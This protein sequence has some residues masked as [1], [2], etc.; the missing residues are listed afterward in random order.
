[1][2]KLDLVHILRAS[3][4]ILNENE[5]LV[6]GSQALWASTDRP[7]KEC[8]ISRD[9]DICPIRAPDKA[10]V[11]SATIGELSQFHDAFGYYAEGIEPHLSVLPKGWRKRLLPMRSEGVSAWCLSAPDL[12]IAKYAAGREKDIAFNKA[13]A[14]TGLVHED[15]L[16]ALAQ[17]TQFKRDG[18]AERV[19]ARIRADF[20]AA[21]LARAKEKG[22]L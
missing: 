7:P 10:D 5:F 14:L 13:L 16:L 4:V 12:A 21:R 11:L 18:D 1:M 15:E 2:Q 22:A 8:L 17:S 9:A 19:A 6:I 3:S 20:K